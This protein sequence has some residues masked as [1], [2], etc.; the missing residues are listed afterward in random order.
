VSVTCW[1]RRITL[2]SCLFALAL[3]ALALA[4]A[5][6]VPSSTASYLLGAKMVRAEVALKSADGKLHDFRIDRGRLVKRYGGGQLVV[7][8]RDATKASIKV[9]S[10]A[11]VLL[12]GKVATVRGLRPGMQVAVP[13]DGNLAADAVYAATKTTPALPAATVQY[14]LGTRMLRSEIALLTPDT[15]LHDYLLDRGRIR[16]LAPY[17]LTL[18]ESDGTSVPL[19]ASAGVRVKLNGKTASFAQLRKGM[20]ATVMR[21]GDKPADQIW[22]TR[23]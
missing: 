19:S 18:R 3:P 10:N 4:L 6:A 13:R 23:K 21:D 22:A 5:R 15:V 14:L 12:N 8:E 1:T 20:T 16:Q 17:S 2:L 11:H 7:V 9:A